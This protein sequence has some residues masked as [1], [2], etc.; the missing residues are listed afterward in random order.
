MTT[1]TNKSVQEVEAEITALFLIGVITMR[2]FSVLREHLHH[3]GYT[4][5]QN[6]RY[7]LEFLEEH[8]SKRER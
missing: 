4:E 1:V 5:E 2:T 3:V 7:V 8:K 6:V